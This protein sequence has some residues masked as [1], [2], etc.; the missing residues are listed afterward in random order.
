MKSFLSTL[1]NEGEKAQAAKKPDVKPAGE[2]DSC[3][4]TNVVSVAGEGNPDA[5][6][7][8]ALKGGG[9]EVQQTQDENGKTTI[10]MK[11]PL[12]EVMTQALDKSYARRPI[13][14]NIDVGIETIF[15]ESETQVSA[16]GQVI[17]T[18][19]AAGA[20]A[21]ASL[22]VGMMPAPTREVTC[23]NAA[24]QAMSAVKA[25]DFAFVDISNLGKNPSVAPLTNSTTKVVALDQN[26]LPGQIPDNVAIE[27]VE[28]VV[29]Y[30]RG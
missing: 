29:K 1:I 14:D 27:S 26:L 4:G 5:N 9:N 16:N 13:P 7:V 18:R 15:T 2:C 10:V 6:Q 28:I 22:L 20:A 21:R 30:K 17:E 23:L 11:G 12:G 3:N 19:P 24:I 8:N 25:V